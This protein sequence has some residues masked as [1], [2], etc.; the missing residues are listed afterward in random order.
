MFLQSLYPDLRVLSFVNR[1]GPIE[2]SEEERSHVLDQPIDAYIARFPTQKS[3]DVLALL[4]SAKETGDSYGG[5]IETWVDGVPV[6]WGE[7]VFDKL[8]ARLAYAMMGIGATCGFEIGA[9][10]ALIDKKGSDIHTDATSSIYGGIRGGISTGERV[11]FCVSFKPTSTIK[12]E[13]LKGRHDPCVLPR[14]VSV[15]E[16]MTW[17][18]L[19]DMALAARLSRA[20]DR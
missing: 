20:L 13:A 10:N 4:K 3:Q 18:T 14:A 11:H 2:L 7:P 5:S 8:K 19:A 15:V 1:I 16:A 9:G 17:A 12:E 6:G